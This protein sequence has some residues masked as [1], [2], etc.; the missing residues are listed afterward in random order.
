VRSRLCVIGNIKEQ[1]QEVVH[2]SFD[3]FLLLPRLRPLPVGS[4]TEVVTSN[5]EDMNLFSSQSVILLHVKLDVI[6]QFLSQFGTAACVIS[7]SLELEATN[8]A[9][10]VSIF[11]YSKCVLVFSIFCYGKTYA[12]YTTTKQHHK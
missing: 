8:P 6:N 3:R 7:W 10:R 5:D 2:L 4:L 11:M 12:V 9:E 1:S